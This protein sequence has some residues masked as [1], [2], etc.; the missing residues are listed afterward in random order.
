MAYRNED[1]PIQ[2]RA[3]AT[4]TIVQVNLNSAVSRCLETL[5]LAPVGFTDA[6]ASGGQLR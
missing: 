6:D 3:A 5:F 1:P 4:N 2:N